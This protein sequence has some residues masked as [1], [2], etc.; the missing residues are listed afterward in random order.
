MLLF[1]VFAVLGG[2]VY[3]TEFRGKE[4]RQ[5]Q[6]ENKKK[7][8][9]V[10]PKDITEL[11]LAYPDRTITAVRK[12]EKQWQIT[13][14]AGLDA[15]SDEWEQLASNVPKIERE[16][17]LAQNVADPGQFGLKDPAVKV[18]AKTKD[19][20]TLEVS[21]GGEN[22]K[23]SHNY[24]KLAGSNDVFLTASNWSK[25]FTKT[26]SDLR[27]KKVL[28]FETD[29]IDS[30]KVLDGTKELE[31]QKAGDDWQLKKPIDTKAD[32]SEI[33]TFTSAIKFA[34]ANSFPEPP[35]DAKTA[36]LDT[37]A[38]K[39]TLHDSKAKAD[40][41]LLIGKSSEKDKY[42]A[43]DGSR[44][45]IFIIDKEIP[46]KARKPIFDW[47]DKSIAKFD[48]EKM[49]KI[50]IQHGSDMVTL[51][52]D[53]SDWK[54]ADGKKAQWD[55]VS[56]M[57]N[58]LDFEKAKDIVDAPKPLPTYG[59]DKPTLQV[60]FRNGANQLLRIDFGKDST[61]PEGIYLKT[62]E[63]PAVKV[64]SKDVSDKFNVKAGDL[65]EAPAADKPKP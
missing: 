36:G 10:E 19:G 4:E 40:R 17:T 9:V 26:A 43:R 54:L 24:A 22:P 34:R 6:E 15:D 48:R 28:E 60:V 44:D 59:L 16:D 65:V 62:S 57:L 37:P 12:G 46:E 50:E 45:V 51:Q 18:S 25:T 14:P 3:F 29:D 23:K 41:T 32:A 61:M 13:S 21:F 49:D 30:V 47:R 31:V 38:M 56:G 7:L 1:L 35:V 42:Y 52:K 53:G 33:S 8:F 39:I 58:G 63:G 2:Y 27:N 64:V 5:K 20:K 55:K 11:T